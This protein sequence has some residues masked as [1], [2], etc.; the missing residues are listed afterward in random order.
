MLN[1]Y[2]HA[3]ARHNR[4]HDLT[5][6]RTEYG[7]DIIILHKSLEKK[8]NFNILNYDDNNIKVRVDRVSTANTR[9]DAMWSIVHA[10]DDLVT[11][12]AFAV[13]RRWSDAPARDVDNIVGQKLDTDS[14][15]RL[16]I[17]LDIRA[18]RP[19]A[20]KRAFVRS[21]PFGPG[22]TLAGT[23]WSERPRRRWA[24]L[25]IWA[26][27]ISRQSAKIVGAQVPLALAV[28]KID[29]VA[30]P[31][32]AASTA[33]SA[34]AASLFAPPERPVA[35]AVDNSTAR[36]TRRRSPAGRTI[37]PTRCPRSPLR[38]VPPVCHRPTTVIFPA[39]RLSPALRAPVRSSGWHRAD[40]KERRRRTRSLRQRL[41]PSVASPRNRPHCPPP[42]V[43]PAGQTRSS[44]RSW[45]LNFSARSTLTSGRPADERR[46]PWTRPRPLCTSP[47]SARPL[48][49]CTCTNPPRS[50][51]GFQ[52]LCSTRRPVLLRIYRFQSRIYN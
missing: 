8:I 12:T 13:A 14:A 1:F 21:A 4:T 52:S 43:A 47:R 25:R 38:V 20:A 22:R 41:V 45:G 32:S 27:R 28:G 36:A 18:P 11:S 50:W 48:A 51:L 39:W 19:F 6:T 34:A 42:S 23:L 44:P 26:F 15:W 10:A 29:P 17:A 49:R 7:Y 35:V 3:A 37:V 2:F 40:R 31:A 9:R 46:K 5:I 24:P 16:R 33:A 30:V